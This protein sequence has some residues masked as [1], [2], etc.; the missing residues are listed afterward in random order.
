MDARLACDAEVAK[1]VSKF[2]G[3]C[4]IGA[5]RLEH[6]LAA[7]PVTL[8]DVRSREERAISTLPGAVPLHA[9]PLPPPPDIPLVLFCTVGYRSAL[10]AT[11]LAEHAPRAG[12][13]S[14]AGILSWAHHGGALLTPAGQMT[15]R[16]HC[17]GSQWAV[18]APS[19][20]ETVVFDGLSVGSLRA[21]LRVPL[22][23]LQN[24]WLWLRSAVVERVLARMLAMVGV[25]GADKRGAQ[26]RPLRA[27]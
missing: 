5:E 23:M 17:F 1:H 4:H 25:G 9:L 2:P 27:S 15:N 24:G 10:E 21:G 18:M 26:G 8:V 13:F 22:V 11:R 3:V 16:V 6:L 19:H 12:I 7:G 20:V 14:M